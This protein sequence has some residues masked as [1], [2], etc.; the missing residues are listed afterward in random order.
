MAIFNNISD[1]VDKVADRLLGPFNI[2]MV[3]EPIDIKISEAIMSFQEHNQEIS[4]RIFTGCGKPV[5]GGGGGAGPFFA[6]DRSRRSPRSIPDFDWNQRANDVDA[7]FEVE[8]TLESLMNDDPQWL[9]LGTPDGIRKVTA[10]MAEQASLRAKFLQYMKGKINLE[11]YEEHERKKRD[12]DPDPAPAGG[13]DIDFKSYEFDKKG[14]K[15]KK[16]LAKSDDSHGKRF[17]S[18]NYYF[19][20]CVFMVLYGLCL[21]IS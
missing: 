21:I 4:Q 17:I 13:M 20:L 12:A 18:E 9:S 7:D 10:E 11:E 15:K 6:P 16:P 1:A 8:G 5:L 2:A 3:V 19:L 14:Q